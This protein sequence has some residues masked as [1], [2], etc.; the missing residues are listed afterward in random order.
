MRRR[1]NEKRDAGCD[2]SEKMGRK[3]ARKGRRE[4]SPREEESHLKVM[5]SDAAEEE[6]TAVSKTLI[7]WGLGWGVAAEGLMQEAVSRV[8]LGS[9]TGGERRRGG[10]G[11]AGIE[12][13]VGDGGE[14]CS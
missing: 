3:K 7:P 8:G 13:G 14:E 1:T 10:E 5:Q 9:G 11:L 6:A 12:E 2:T 4:Q